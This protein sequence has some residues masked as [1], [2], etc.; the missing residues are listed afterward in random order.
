M[1]EL[2][3]TPSTPAQPVPKD[4]KPYRTPKLQEFGKLHLQTLGPSGGSGDG[5]SGMMR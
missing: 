3:P 1:K 4:L 5:A 2:E